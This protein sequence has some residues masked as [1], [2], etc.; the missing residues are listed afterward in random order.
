M[1]VWFPLTAAI[2]VL[3]HTAGCGGHTGSSATG[4]AV[5]TVNWP[6][7][8]RLISVASNSI[9][10]TIKLGTQIIASQVL[11]RPT[12]GG[13]ATAAFENL[14]VG[15]LTFSATAHPNAD[16]SGVAQAFGSAPL[17]VS[18]GQTTQLTVTMDS[19]IDHLEMSPNTLTVP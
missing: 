16:G 14:K 3:V 18:A 6:K 7:R 13:T 4:R 9:K 1:K 2:A 11:P 5:L 19:T 17:I 15:S 10:A 12:D 8:S